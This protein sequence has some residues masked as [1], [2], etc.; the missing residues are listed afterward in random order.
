VVGIVRNMVP[1]SMDGAV[2][3]NIDHLDIEGGRLRLR[4]SYHLKG[5][6]VLVGCNNRNFEDLYCTFADYTE[7]G[8]GTHTLLAEG[9][10]L[11]AQK[12][13][14][15]GSAEARSGSAEA[16]FFVSQYRLYLPF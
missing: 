5:T 4:T 3:Q 1:V 7:L 12:Q 10:K 13:A 11:D 8:S 2:E 15:F 16:H 14:R 9:K 6:V